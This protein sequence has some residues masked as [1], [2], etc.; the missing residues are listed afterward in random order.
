[1][2][3]ESPLVAKRRIAGMVSVAFGIPNLIL[4]LLFSFSGIAAA[5]LLG[6]LAFAM[7]ND[8]SGSD[9]PL[10]QICIVMLII[11][12]IALIIAAVLF[13]IIAL[14]FAAAMAGQS[15]GG[16]YAIKGIHF[17]RSV[18]LI[19][20]GSLIALMVGVSSI[21]G[22]LNSGLKDPSDYGYLAFGVFEVLSF[23]ASLVSGIIVLQAR[24]TFKEPEKKEKKKKGKGKKK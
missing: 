3:D 8:D 15:L 23:V 10:G 17:G 24:S 12:L 9:N 22:G 16:Y 4:G 14:V 21:I 19:F 11:I 1:M 2:E 7:Y 13:T 20:L 6:V 18:T 5:I